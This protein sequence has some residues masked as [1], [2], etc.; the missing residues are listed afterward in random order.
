[1]RRRNI[2]N[3]HERLINDSIF[4]LNYEEQCGKWNQLF[5]NDNPI[6]LEIGM[7]KGN[8]IIENLTCSKRID[9]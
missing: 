2:K 5:N 3:A 6:Y 7:G 8:F 4:V 1:M 9:F